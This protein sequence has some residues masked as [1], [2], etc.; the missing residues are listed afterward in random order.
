[1]L[2]SSFRDFPRRGFAQAGQ[3]LPMDVEISVWQVRYKLGI[4]VTGDLPP[5][6]GALLCTD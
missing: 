4:P 5:R 3:G 6:E 2:T 1:L